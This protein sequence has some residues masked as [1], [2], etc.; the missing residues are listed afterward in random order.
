M[1]RCVGLLAG[2]GRRGSRPGPLH[3][4]RRQGSLAAGGE[5]LTSVLL[6]GA[7]RPYFKGLSG[8][9]GVSGLPGSWQ[10]AGDR[11]SG[12]LFML[13]TL[14]GP[15][16]SGIPPSS[17]MRDTHHLVTGSQD[18]A[19]PGLRPVSVLDLEGPFPCL[20]QHSGGLVGHLGGGLVGHLGGGLVGHP[21]GGLWVTSV[22]VRCD[23]DGC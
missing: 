16:A 22:E 18:S 8:D 1:E 20:S 14:I 11:E 12:S 23:S 4:G 17:G 21:G 7:R 10:V 9:A 2:P 15:L 13:L 5:V 19:L 3:V 6:P